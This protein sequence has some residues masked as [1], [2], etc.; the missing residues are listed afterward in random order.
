[1]ALK[2]EST[3]QE[4]VTGT[5]NAMPSGPKLTPLPATTAAPR[6]AA[7]GISNTVIDGPVVRFAGHAPG[8]KA[9]VT[10]LNS[11]A[12]PNVSVLLLFGAGKV[13]FAKTFTAPRLSNPWINSME[14][15][16]A[17]QLT[18]AEKLLFVSA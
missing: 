8:G 11:P 13:F 5:E 17:E 14:N 10:A 1:M 7:G 9:I 3:G 12:R 15:P 18:I 2:P 16:V 4:I 6:L